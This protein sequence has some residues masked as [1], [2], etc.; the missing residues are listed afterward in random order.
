MRKYRGYKAP[1][2]WFSRELSYIE[3]GLYA[4]W[5]GKINRW[6]IH[7]TDNSLCLIVQNPKTKAYRDLDM[8]TIRKLKIN[9][10]FTHNDKAMMLFLDDARKRTD[11]DYE[12]RQ[13]MERG[14]D[15]ISDYLSGWDTD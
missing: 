4:K 2:N 1:H 7:H 15:G 11:V 3:S 14:L 13:Y 9:A 5:H 12:L 8:R 6:F 10:F